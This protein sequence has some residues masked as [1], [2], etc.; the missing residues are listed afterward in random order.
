MIAPVDEAG[1][2]ADLTYAQ[3]QQLAVEVSLHDPSRLR[4]AV[5]VADVNAEEG[6]VDLRVAGPF[7]EDEHLRVQ[8]V[9]IAGVGMTDIEWRTG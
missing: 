5:G 9:E 1:L 6:W 7:G 4:E 8:L 2:V 3:R